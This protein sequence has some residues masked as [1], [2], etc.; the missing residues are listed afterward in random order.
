MPIQPINYLNSQILKSPWS[1]DFASMLQ[2]GMALR[3][4]PQRLLRQKEQEELSNILRKEQGLQAQAETPFAGPRAEADIIYK[5][6]QAKAADQQANMP[7][8]G[9]LTGVANEAL[10]LELLKQQYGPDSEVYKNAAKRYQADLE[11]SNV[12]NQYRQALSGT[13]EKRASTTLGKTEREIEDIYKRQDLSPQEKEAMIERY[14]LQRQKQISDSDSRK[15]ALFASNVDKTLA[16]I[17][18]KA[19]TQYG[20]AKGAV[21]FEVDK[22]K[23]AAGKAPKE[24]SEYQKSLTGAKLLAKQIRQ[25]YGDSITPQ[26]QQSLS[27]MVNPATWVN[28]PQVALEKF[29]QFKDILQSETETYRSALKGTEEFKSSDENKKNK[30]MEILKKQQA[31]ADALRKQQPRMI[32]ESENKAASPIKRF[33]YVNGAW[34]SA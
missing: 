20:G 2:K 14:S 18:P 26:V 13:A 33:K 27:E 34:I 30:N 1:Q 17:N 9:R 23:S 22:L 11:Q 10:G 29:N 28:N 4:E 15:R 6:A 3:H 19:L 32:G 24:Y 25:F 7:F 12:L 31:M 8:G 5:Q 16:Q 21:K